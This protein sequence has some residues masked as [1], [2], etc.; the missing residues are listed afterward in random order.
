[1]YNLPY[2]ISNLSKERFA[3]LCV[4]LLKLE[5]SPNTRQVTHQGRDGLR[6]ATLVG[7]CATRRYVGWSGYWVFQFKQYQTDLKTARSSLLRDFKKELNAVIGDCM[8]VDNYIFIT[9]VPFSGIPKT[10][11]SDRIRSIIAEVIKESHL[12]VDVWDGLEICNIIDRYYSDTRHYFTDCTPIR[13]LNQNFDNRI[14]N[15][16]TNITLP[17]IPTKYD[18]LCWLLNELITPS[19]LVLSPDSPS[20]LWKMI[21]LGR[22]RELSEFLSQILLQIKNNP[23]WV[24]NNNEMIRI[25][26]WIEVALAFSLAKRGKL[27]DSKNIIIDTLSRDLR[28][29]PDIMAWAYNVLSIIYGKL[30]DDV[31]YRRFCRLA[32]DFAKQCGMSWLAINIQMRI[33]HKQ[34]WNAAENDIPLQN[35]FFEDYLH[36]YSNDDAICSSEEKNSIRA[37]RSA[38]LALHYGWQEKY[39]ERAQKEALYAIECFGQTIDVPEI[40]RMRSELGRI[41]LY[42]TNNQEM[43]RHYLTEGARLRASIDDICRLRYDLS[44]LAE[45]YLLSN[46][47]HHAEWCAAVGCI[48]HHNLYGKSSVDK[49]LIKRYKKILCNDEGIIKEWDKIATNSFLIYDLLEEITGIS[50]FTWYNLLPHESLIRFKKNYYE[51]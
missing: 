21:C 50:K 15:L 9:S 38:Y 1:M 48:L 33:L 30:D 27:I 22:F 24:K 40:A 51:M 29:Y 17:C 39:L 5:I 26:S 34:S 46:R 12:N 18:D 42:H 35:E 19:C 31:H 23:T 45:S 28:Q 49:G 37:L 47:K 44:W 11:T 32:I 8:H 2:P 13:S 10:G 4:T 3:S 36:E 16:Y 25:I 43:A 6:D 7:P 20:D 14:V 41:F